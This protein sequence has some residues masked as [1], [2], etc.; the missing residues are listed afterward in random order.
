MSMSAPLDASAN[1]DRFYTVIKS[2]HEF[3][4]RE[5]N[6]VVQT[7]LS[8]TPRE[9]CFVGTYYRTLGNVETLLRMD[10][11]KDFQAIAMLARALFELAVEIRLLETI[12]D[13]WDKMLAYSDFQKLRTANKIIAFKRQNPSSDIDTTAYDIFVA[14]NS[15]K[16]AGFLKSM[17]G[18]AKNPNHWSGLNLEA[19]S[20]KL[21]LPYN[22]VYAVDYS[23]LSWYVH[24]GLAGVINV[25]AVTFIHLCAYAFH[26]AA[27]AYGE[28]LLSIIRTFNIGK[29]NAQIESLLRLAKELPFTDTPE[30][31]EILTQMRSGGR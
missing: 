2:M 18:G 31:A 12:P 22:Q 7:L 14:R 9:D 29:A 4:K 16:V 11:A 5:V 10:K 3:D 30:Q 23:R 17:W 26:L 1:T 19:R 6:G 21:G 8:L 25:P 13:G 24:P 28:S 20:V 15:A 27:T